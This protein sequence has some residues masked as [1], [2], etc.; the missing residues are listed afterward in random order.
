VAQEYVYVIAMRRDDGWLPPVKVGITST[1]KQRLSS[2]QSGSPVPL[3]IFHLFRLRD[4]EVSRRIERAILEIKAS[5]RLHGEWLSLQPH[6]AAEVIALYIGTHFMA[7]G[8]TFAEAQPLMVEA[9]ALPAD[10]GPFTPNFG[11]LP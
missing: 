7:A 1:P 8:L 4:R 11:A 5:A 2:L 9:G 6:Y 10:G 3:T